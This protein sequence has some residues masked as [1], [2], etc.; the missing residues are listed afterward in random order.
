MNKGYD[1]L[2]YYHPEFLKALIAFLALTLFLAKNYWEVSIS[3][4][5]VISGAIVVISTY[6]WKYRPFIWMFWVDDFSGRYEGYLKYHYQ[7]D[8]GEMQSDE[9][10]HVK[11]INQNGNRIVVTSFTIKED[12]TKSSISVS[13][14]MFVEKTEDEKHYRL[15]YNYYNEGSF[16]DR[17]PPH[18]GTEVIK[19]IKN[20]DSH[21]LT[22]EYYTG[23]EPYQT[24]GEF[25][26]LKKVSNDLNH[27]F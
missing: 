20:D 14:G 15:I 12:G 18:Y 5:G 24:K 4:L 25:I 17:L 11:V 2:K 8:K 21:K 6:L 13:K 7:N 9:L 27:E 16:S 23:R 10:K 26:N 3:I 19:F 22:G 1:Y